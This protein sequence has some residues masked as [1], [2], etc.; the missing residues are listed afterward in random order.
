MNFQDF[1]QEGVI[2]IVKNLLAEITGT[3]FSF[4]KRD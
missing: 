1:E 4:L 2:A 3:I